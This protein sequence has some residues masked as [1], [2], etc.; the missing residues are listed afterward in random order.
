MFKWLCTFEKSV[1]AVEYLFLN[2]GIK[3]EKSA[4]L[5]INIP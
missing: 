3:T 5:K 4:T 2:A 1:I